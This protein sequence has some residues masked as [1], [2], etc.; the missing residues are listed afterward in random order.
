MWSV[1]TAM[2]IPIFYRSKQRQGVLESEASQAEARREVEA[3]KLMISSGIR[4]NHAMAVTA[5]RL[6]DLYRD[7]LIPKTHQDFESAL[8]GYSSGSNDALTVINR[9]KALVDFELLYWVQFSER[10][11]ALARIEAAAGLRA[12]SREAEGT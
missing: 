8:A 3:T 12:A 2:N 4:D 1:T 11:K 9:L 6:M 7:G 10:E 5:G